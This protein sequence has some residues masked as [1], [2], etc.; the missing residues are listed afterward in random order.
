MHDFPAAAFRSVEE[1]NET[2]FKTRGHDDRCSGICFEPLEPSARFPFW[3]DTGYAA[4][5][6]FGLALAFSTMPM[7]IGKGRTA[8]KPDRHEGARDD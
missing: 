7:K 2:E 3:M 8:K 1:R 4:S 5:P 6:T